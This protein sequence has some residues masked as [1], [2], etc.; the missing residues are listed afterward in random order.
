[1]WTI[2]K[3][4]TYVDQA[5]RRGHFPPMR[6]LFT[7]RKILAYYGFLGDG[8][9]GDE[10]VFEAAKR[11]FE[12]NIL[13]LIKRRMPVHLAVWSRICKRRF[14]GIVIGGG[15]LLCKSFYEP[16]FFLH[17]IR[18]GKPICLLGTGAMARNTWNSGWCEVMERRVWGGVRGPLSVRNAV[19][20]GEK[21]RVVGDAAFSLFRR[22]LVSDKGVKGNTVLINLGTHYPFDGLATSRSAVERFVAEVIGQGFEVKFLPCHGIDISLGGELAKRHSAIEVLSIPKSYEEAER[23]FRGS[24]FAVGE[25]LH[26]TVMAM[27]ARCPFFS[28]NYEEKHEDALASVGLSGAGCAPRDVSAEGIRTAFETRARFD[29]ANALERMEQLGERQREEARAFLGVAAH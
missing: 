7:R 6:A 11:L 16:S 23:H 20:F 12:P 8:N 10:L 21:L 18:L 17:L 15:T 19:E 27:L 3:L 5:Y 4:A 1:M 26:F 2:G 14:D 24:A 25:R 29:W 9:F 13:L 22:E 28:V